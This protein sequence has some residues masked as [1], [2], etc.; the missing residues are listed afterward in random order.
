MAYFLFKL[1]RR[2]IR[3]NK[4][5]KAT[6][7]TNESHLVPEIVS[8]H[9]TNQQLYKQQDVHDA[10]GATSSSQSHVDPIDPEEAARHKAESRQRNIRQLKLM[11]GLALPNFLA[12]I[13]VTIVAPAIPLISSHFGKSY[14]HPSLTSRYTNSSI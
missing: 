12:S 9:Q 7:T 2:K 5:K 10:V 11:L 6:P 13:D 4:A 3:E 8:G 14:F 1:I